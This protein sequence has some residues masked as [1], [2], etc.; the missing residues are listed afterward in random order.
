[1]SKTFDALKKA[2]AQGNKNGKK[3]GN[4]N[5]NGS[6]LSRLGNGRN[7]SNGH[8]E[9]P[10]IDLHSTELAPIGYQRI[11]VWL[12]NPP[13]GQRQQTVMVCGCRS[14]SG[15][16]TT[17]ALLASTL[18][19]GRK[20][21]VLIVDGNFRT[22]SLNMVFKV[23]DNGGFTDVLAGDK[24]LEAQIQSTTRE[25]LFVLTSGKISDMPIEVFEGEA[26]E[27]LTTH[28]KQKFDFIVFDGAPA[29]EY[30]D[31]CALAPKMDAVILVVQ[32]EG[33][34]VEEA[35]RVKRDLERAGAF[36]MGVVVNR[37]KE[38]IPPS[39]RKFLGA[40]Y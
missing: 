13:Q 16:T 24:P 3:N 28:L 5:G 40:P 21:K 11:R 31:A 6:W 29:L 38:Y 25:N 8:K 15:S 18:A 10:E 17:A 20:S 7:G 4:R 2:E 30:P 9:H 34:P 1:M 12:N 22:P 36:I 35:Q 23:K 27:L 14:G 19:E 39:F 33:T 32:S 37:Y 26:V